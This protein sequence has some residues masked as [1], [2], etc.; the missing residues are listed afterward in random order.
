MCAVG[1][2]NRAMAALMT[3]TMPSRFEEIRTRRA[4][5]VVTLADRI[6]GLA[7]GTDDTALC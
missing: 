4:S 3:K 2:H 1:L 5:R 7:I 6:Y